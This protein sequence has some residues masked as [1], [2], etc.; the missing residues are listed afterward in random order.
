M[1][2]VRARGIALLLLLAAL[3]VAGCGGGQDST[4]AA[5]RSPTVNISDYTY[6]PKTLTIP[7]GSEVTFE[8]EDTT[9]HTATSKQSGAFDTD[10][11]APGKSATITFG[12]PGTFV[13][14]CLFHPF[15][16][17]TVKVEQWRSP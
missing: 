11:I 16:K 3:A 12:E 10:S 9:A 14:Y 4:S 6:G 7:A 15:M 2:S 5:S 1:G 17:G 8:N 13:Y